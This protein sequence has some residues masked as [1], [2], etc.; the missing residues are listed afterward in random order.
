MA[1]VF[2]VYTDGLRCFRALEDLGHAHTVIEAPTRRQACRAD[3]ATW[4]NIKRAMDG[5][6]HA[7]DF[8]KYAQRYLT[9]TAWRFNRRFHLA[10]IATDLIF[11]LANSAPCPERRLR[12]QFHSAEASN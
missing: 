7:F 11:A 6:Y 1:P 3:G 9:E 10:S 4:V 5:P 8:T 12:H 2:E